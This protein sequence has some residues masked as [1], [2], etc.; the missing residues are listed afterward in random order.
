MTTTPMKPMYATLLSALSFAALI[1]SA[2]A[3]DDVH[4]HT[5]EWIAKD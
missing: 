4:T 1:G 3:E 5:C 2:Q